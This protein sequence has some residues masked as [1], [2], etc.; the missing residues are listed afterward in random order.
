MSCQERDVGGQREEEGTGAHTGSRTA[1]DCDP[2]TPGRPANFGIGA[3]DLRQE[4][5]EVGLDLPPIEEDA[6][7]ERATTR[8]GLEASRRTGCEHFRWKPQ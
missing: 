8:L 6:A 7:F 3:V 4:G 2:L 5:G 1:A